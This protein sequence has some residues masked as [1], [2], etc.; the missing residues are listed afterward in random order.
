MEY[1]V[2]IGSV[3][4]D[5]ESGSSV[6]VWKIDEEAAAKYT[7]AITEGFGEPVS[8]IL[9]PRVLDILQE[10]PDTVMLVEEER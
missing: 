9:S 3:N 2:S 6:V 7:T 4:E 5:G 8:A 1:F 10:D